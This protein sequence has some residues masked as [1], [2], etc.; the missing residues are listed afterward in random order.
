MGEIQGSIW[1]TMLF[2]TLFFGMTGVLFWSLDI[3]DMNSTRYTIEDNIRAGNYE[4][5]K[6]LDED[7]NVCND[8]L[9][10]TSE[11]VVPTSDLSVDCTGI[12]EINTTQRY[13]KYKLS[14]DGLLANVDATTTDGNVVILPY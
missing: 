11:E 3:M 4:I 10:Y 7:Y 6:E 1:T 5:F 9:L 14:Y 12:I 2:I 8:L 13:V